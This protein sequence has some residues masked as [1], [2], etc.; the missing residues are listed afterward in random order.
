MK[1]HRFD[2]IA[3]QIAASCPGLRADTRV[4]YRGDVVAASFFFLR[5]LEDI[6]AQIHDTK[7]AQLKA[8]EFVQVLPNQDPLAERFTTRFRDWTG[9]KAKRSA[10]PTDTA[11]LAFTLRKEESMDYFTYKEGFSYSRDELAKA[12]KYGDPIDAERALGARRLLAQSL[13]SLIATGDAE[14]SM[15]GLL[16]LSNTTSFSMP[17]TGTGSST[18]WSTK[19]PDNILADMQAIYNA[20]PAATLD[21]ESVKRMVLPSTLYRLIN[22]TARSANSDLTILEYFKRNHPDCAVAEWERL[23]DSS[24]DLYGGSTVGANGTTAGSGNTRILAGDFGVEN[25][26]ALTSIEAEMLEPE[27]KG[28]GWTIDIKMKHAGVDVRYPKAILYADGA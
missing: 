6:E 9:V 14:V 7:Y 4:N 2:S 19:T 10:N 5:Q 20:I 12:A 17:T 11:P 24:A 1:T 21:V 18:L 28:E 23:S 8:L 16:T 3:K 26:R 13:D 27:R 22:A 15:P 25:V